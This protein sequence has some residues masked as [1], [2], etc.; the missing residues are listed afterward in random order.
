M[1][2]EKYTHL[3][4]AIEQACAG[5]AWEATLLPGRG[6]GTFRLEIR[7]TAEAHRQ[8]FENQGPHMYAPEI[9]YTRDGFQIQTTSHG[10]LSASEIERLAA[11]YLRATQLVHDLARIIG[12]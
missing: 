4:S 5:T 9:R 7:L 6:E 11:A 10:T 3:S 1:T 8:Q 12:G 2:T